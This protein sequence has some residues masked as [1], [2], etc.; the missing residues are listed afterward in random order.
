MENC[1]NEDAFFAWY[2]SISLV[3]AGNRMGL[4]R[5]VYSQYAET[6]ESVFVLPANKTRS[7]AEESYAYTIEDL[8]KCGAST[9]FMYF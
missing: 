6:G 4:L 8:G 1:V 7:G 5:E 2:D 9:V 3:P